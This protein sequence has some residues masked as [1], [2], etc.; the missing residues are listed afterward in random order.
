MGIFDSLSSLLRGGNNMFSGGVGSGMGAG[1]GQS[2]SN[3]SSGFGGGGILGKILGGI[4]R[5]IKKNPLETAMVAGSIMSSRQNRGLND[6]QKRL[7]ELEAR[8]REDQARL[9]QAAIPMLMKLMASGPY[10]NNMPNIS[11][12]LRQYGVQR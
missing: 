7:L 2:V 9:R 1:V 6:A 8:K 12:L 5:T 4:G 10:S 3:G 11:E